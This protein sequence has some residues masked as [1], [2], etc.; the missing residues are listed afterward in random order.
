MKQN[1]RLKRVIV[2][3]TLSERVDKGTAGPGNLCRQTIGV[4]VGERKLRH[5]ARLAEVERELAFGS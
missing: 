2:V 5:S 3:Q 4:A 1:I